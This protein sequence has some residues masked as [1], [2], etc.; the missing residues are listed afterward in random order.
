VLSNARE[1][2]F[3]KIEATMQ[4]SDGVGL[5]HRLLLFATPESRLL[6]FYV[7]LLLD[8]D[9]DSPRGRDPPCANCVTQWHEPGGWN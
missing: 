8:N 1:R 4:V 7:D 3:E 9:R 6:V 5:T 2:H